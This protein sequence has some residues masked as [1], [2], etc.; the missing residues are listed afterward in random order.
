MGNII[1][2]KNEG[3][4]GVFSQIKLNGGERVLISI[5]ADEI[6]IFK[7]GFLAIPTKTIWSFSDL[8]KFSDLLQKNN[9]PGHPLDVLVGMIKDLDSIDQVKKELSNFVANLEPNKRAYDP[10]NDLSLKDKPF[11]SKLF[12]RTSNLI[13]SSERDLRKMVFPN[14]LKE[15]IKD[16]SLGKFAI[17]SIVTIAH[18]ITR[19]SLSENIDQSILTSTPDKKLAI[20]VVFS[21]FC[22]NAIKQLIN[23]EKIEVDYKKLKLDHLRLFFITE[24]DNERANVIINGEKLFNEEIAKDEPETL[25]WYN[26]LLNAINLYVMSYGDEE[27]AAKATEVIQ[28][29]FKVCESAYK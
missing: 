17:T 26:N 6:K 12:L 11:T 13:E 8:F 23:E 20:V 2:Y 18:E 25:K 15:T 21:L 3:E 24:K 22:L 10:L 14:E 28:V 7:L 19:K 5:A 16:D 9:H 27:K 1:T 4:K 29:L